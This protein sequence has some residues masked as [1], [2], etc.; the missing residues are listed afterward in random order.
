MFHVSFSSAVEDKKSEN[1]KKGLSFFEAGQ[2]QEAFDRLLEAFLVEPGDPDIDFYLGRAAFEIGDFEMALMAFERILITSPETERVKLEMARCYFKL[3]LNENAKEIFEEVLSSNPPDAVKSNIE[4]YLSVIKEK[5]RRH[6]LDGYFFVGSDWDDNARYSP[7][8]EVI[9]TVI[10]DIPIDEEYRAREDWI[11]NW[12]G[13]L[14]YTYLI[15]DSRVSWQTELIGY[16]SWYQDETD[17]NTLYAGIKAGPAFQFDRLTLRMNGFF[18]YL[19]LDSEAY[20]QS[21]GIEPTFTFRMGKSAWMNII[22]RGE[23]K[24]YP[25]SPMRNADNV[26]FALSPIFSI[27]RSRMSARVF[28][29]IEDAES[30]VYSYTRYGAKMSCER[31]VGSRLSVFLSYEYQYREY[32]GIEPL[33]DVRRKDHLHYPAAGVNVTLRRDKE[34]RPMFF[35]NTTYRYT[36]SESNIE[37]YDYSKN[38]VSVSL[39]HSF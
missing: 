31:N 23:S 6:F 39:F 25:D 3:G 4:K 16:Q 24:E 2:Y 29:E 11:Y 20:Y 27:W 18:D 1:F 9:Q 35:L 8:S 38:V 5:E 33:F 14:S 28:Y 34:R 7:A 10:D 32:D 36:G 37:L 19:T 12:S 26:Y 17:L 13:F 22:L 21:G 15:P 30:D